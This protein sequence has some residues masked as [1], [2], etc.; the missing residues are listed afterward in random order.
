MPR[1]P[2]GRIPVIVR[3]VDQDGTAWL[4]P[5][6]ANRWTAEAV[7]VERPAP[8]GAARAYRLN[9]LAATDVK[10]TVQLQPH[11]NGSAI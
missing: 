11:P 6:I 8:D 2:M 10:R 3:L 4:V 1:E 7:L 5:G 9:W